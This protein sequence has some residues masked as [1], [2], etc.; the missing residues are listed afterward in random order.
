[1]T[2]MKKFNWGWGIALFYTS[3]AVFI[4][5]LVY[6]TTT[7]NIDLVT[8]DYYK[9]ELAH[10]DQIDKANRANSLTEPLQWTVTNSKVVLS[11]PKEVS[12]KNVKASVLFYRPSDSAKDLKL[13]VVPDTSGSCVINSDK[14]YKGV[15][16]MQVDWSADNVAYYNEGVVNIN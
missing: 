15:Y 12:A 11:F 2:V 16:R 9:K 13:E 8:P 10:Q 4:L 6:K 14:L 7:L 1:M 5:L 3:F